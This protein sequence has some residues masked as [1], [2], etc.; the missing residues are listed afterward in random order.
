MSTNDKNKLDGI[1]DGAQVN[2][3]T[4]LSWTSGTTAGP[5]VNSSTGADAVMPTASASASGAVTTGTQTWA[6]NK[7]FN[8]NVR[9]ASFGVNTAASGTAGEIRATNNITAFF[10]DD[11]L[12]TRLSLVE[13][14]LEKINT[15]DAFFYIPNKTATDL[16]YK[17]EKYIGLSAQQ[18]NKIF[19]E[20]VK[21]APIDDKYLTIQYD[22]LIPVLVAAIKEIKKE[23]DLMQKKYNEDDK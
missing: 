8:N 18:V 9:V 13:D 16:G 10:S 3:S 12:K 1:D 14:A 6:G 2:I 17:E 15:L 21:P 23:I 19:P 20:I 11:R 4:D 5:R 22:K 7:T